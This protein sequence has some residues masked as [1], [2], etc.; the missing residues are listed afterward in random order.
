MRNG[1]HELNQV[2]VIVYGFI[3][4]HVNVIKP[5]SNRSFSQHRYI[6]INIKTPTLLVAGTLLQSNK[7]DWEIPDVYRSMKFEILPSDK[8]A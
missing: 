7:T 5:K 1:D 3:W 6:D 4:M 2:A 8:S